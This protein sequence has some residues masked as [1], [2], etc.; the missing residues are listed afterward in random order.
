LVGKQLGKF[1]GQYKVV[2][3]EASFGTEIRHCIDQLL[4]IQNSME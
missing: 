2:V 1:D 4:E 3:G